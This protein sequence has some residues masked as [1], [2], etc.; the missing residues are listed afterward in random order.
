MAAFLAR[1]SLPRCRGLLIFAIILLFLAPAS[2]HAYAAFDDAQAAGALLS[3]KSE[4]M[5][6]G[7][8]E[9]ARDIRHTTRSAN[10][11]DIFI[12]II[13]LFIS[14]SRR[15]NNLAYSSHLQSSPRASVSAHYVIQTP[16]GIRVTQPSIHIRH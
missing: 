13:T 14:S 16:I 9:G 12:V 1:F 4:D 11:A 2:R 10:R 5:Y 7:L 15:R 8:R 6:A 3:P